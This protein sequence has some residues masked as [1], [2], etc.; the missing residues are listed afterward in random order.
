MI[1]PGTCRRLSAAARAGRIAA[2]D[3]HVW[4]LDMDRAL[5]AAAGKL[6]FNEAGEGWIEAR[7]SMFRDV[8]L[9]RRDA[10]AS[11]HLCVTYD[12]ALQGVTLVTRA[13]DLLPAT[14]VHVLLQRLMG[15]PT[16]DYAH[17][18]LIRGAGGGRLSK[19]DGAPTVR[20]LRAAGASPAHVFQLAGCSVDCTTV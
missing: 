19:R 2:G 15:W 1:Y 20:G 18:R 13:D 6:G 4:R 7:P 3:P 8:V 17:H 10:P 12:D 11:Y 16:P 14:H 9:G 5:G